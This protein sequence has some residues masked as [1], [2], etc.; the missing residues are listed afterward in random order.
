MKS[1]K[2]YS[3]FFAIVFKRGFRSKANTD[4]ISRNIYNFMCFSIKRFSIVLPID[5]RVKTCADGTEGSDTTK[6][7]DV[8]QQR[9]SK[10]SRIDCNQNDSNY[11]SNNNNN[12]DKTDEKRLQ[13]IKFNGYKENDMKE[14]NNNNDNHLRADQSNPF[15]KNFQLRKTNSIYWWLRLTRT[16]GDWSGLKGNDW[17]SNGRHDTTL[18][19]LAIRWQPFCIICTEEWQILTIGYENTEILVTEMTI[20][21]Y[22]N[23]F[24][25]LES[26][27]IIK[28]Q[29][30]YWIK[31]I[32][33]FESIKNSCD[34]CVH[35]MRSLAAFNWDNE[36]SSH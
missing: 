16:E 27:I 30:F 24:W 3:N 31:F 8:S 10:K 18:L 34:Q 35:R 23:I 5:N 6:P 33:V 17:D 9:V 21:C 19:S 22:I 7:D 32:Y 1:D 25:F 15:L 14:E 12:N 11:E 36:V 26:L 29:L 13:E 28:Y 2:N 4:I 20:D